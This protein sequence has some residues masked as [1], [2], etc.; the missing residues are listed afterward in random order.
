[1]RGQA[2]GGTGNRGSSD[3][4]SFLSEPGTLPTPRRHV[5]W[6]D[7]ELRTDTAEVGDF[8]VHWVEAGG[9]GE[10]VVLL[11]GLSGSSRWWARNISALA[12]RHRVLV[13]DVIG[14]GRSRLHGGSLPSMPTLAG[15]IADWIALA[16]GE[17]AHLVGHSMGG[18][19]AVHVAARHAAC[20]RRLALVDAAGIPRLLTPRYL[21]R[22]AYEVAPPRRWGDP[23]FLPVI[24]GDA[25]SAGPA[26]LLRAIRHILRDDVRPLLGEIS[27][28]TM[29]LWG[30]RDTIVPVAH[31][32]VFRR[33]IP[34]SL[35]KVL[36]GTYHNPMV[37]DPG[38]FN[39]AILAFLSGVEVG[40]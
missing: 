3:P 5:R 40:S 12:H 16:A 1:L 29:I 22:F 25:L 27:A 7:L 28:P 26:T 37:D 13:P 38:A 14:F 23:S 30:E 15:V 6:R 19:L 11:H 33:G 18:Q 9:D 21:M 32:E 8:R 10:P 31:G 35:L 4:E 20:V 2:P 24:V 17:P 39:A 36:P 34:G